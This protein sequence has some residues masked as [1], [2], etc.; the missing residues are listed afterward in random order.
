MLEQV[1]NVCRSPI[2]LRAWRRGQE[3]SVHAWI[4]DIASGLLHDLKATI[5]GDRHAESTIDT[6]IAGPRLF[7]TRT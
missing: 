6:A 5:D 4:Y 3:I 7:S 2:V 1:R